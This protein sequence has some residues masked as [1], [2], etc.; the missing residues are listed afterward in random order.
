MV[1]TWDIRMFGGSRSSVASQRQRQGNAT[2]QAPK[3]I[4]SYHSSLS[5]NSAFFSP[6]GQYVVSTTMANR[7]DIFENAH[8][9]LAGSATATTM[10]PTTTVNHDNRTGR[11]LSTFMARW[12]PEL[13][14]FVVG[15]MQRPRSMEVFH[16][17]RGQDDHNHDERRGNNKRLMLQTIQGDALT[18]VASRCCFHRS[19]DKL[20]IVG[21]NSSGRVTVVR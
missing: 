11:W 18:A 3:P 14:I 2:R 17:I 12:H 19:T 13:D 4:A 1:R 15:S 6:S 9:H 16:S 8:L 5:V 10:K 7:L 21:G 20:I